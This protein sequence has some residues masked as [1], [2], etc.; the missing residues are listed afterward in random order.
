MAKKSYLK[1]L[2]PILLV[3]IMGS[4]TSCFLFFMDWIGGLEGDWK[5]RNTAINETVYLTITKDTF[6]IIF[7]EDNPYYPITPLYFSASP[8]YFNDWGFKGNLW[9]DEGIHR[10]DISIYQLYRF[11]RLN[12]KIM[13]IVVKGHS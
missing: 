8:V 4:V 5:Y 2:L 11:F 9:V 13:K 1:I 6:K 12:Y 10:M 3:V 7:D